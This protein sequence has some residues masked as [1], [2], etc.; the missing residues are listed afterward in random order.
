MVALIRLYVP[1]GRTKMTDANR[2]DAIKALTKA[3]E[4]LAAED[5]ED[6]EH[7]SVVYHLQ[8]AMHCAD[9]KALSVDDDPSD[10]AEATYNG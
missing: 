6:I 7:H 3:I 1:K 2:M 10:I 9:I 8:A 4:A 5:Y